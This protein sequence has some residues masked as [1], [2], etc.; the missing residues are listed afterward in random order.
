MFTLL[1]RPV[2]KEACKWCLGQRK[3]RNPGHAERVRCGGCENIRN[4]WTAT[5]SNGAKP[6]TDKACVKTLATS[7]EHA[8]LPPR[9]NRDVVRS[10]S[11]RRG[12]VSV[13]GAPRS[14]LIT[15]SKIG[16]PC[17]DGVPLGCPPLVDP[18]MSS[19]DFEILASWKVVEWRTKA[20]DKQC[21]R[22]HPEDSTRTWTPPPIYEI[23]FANPTYDTER[24]SVTFPVRRR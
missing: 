10:R 7:Q 1:E 14:P 19:E 9:P 2:S 18:P 4:R 15:S 5:K 11:P 13:S 8:P 3:P 23:N 24:C 16:W 12:P 22:P 21:K 17:V 20:F 6:I